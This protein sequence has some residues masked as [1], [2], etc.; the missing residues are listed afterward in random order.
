MKDMEQRIQEL[1][2]GYSDHSHS[3]LTGKGKG[4]NDRLSVS[5]PAIYPASSEPIPFKKKKK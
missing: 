3:Y 1:E 4:H 5:G 2:Q